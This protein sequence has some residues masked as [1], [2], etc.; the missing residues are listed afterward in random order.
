MVLN[1]LAFFHMDY[2]YRNSCEPCIFLSKRCPIQDKQLWSNFCIINY[3]T[4]LPHT[5]EP[6]WR[7]LVLVISV[8]KGLWSVHTAR[9]W[10]LYS[11]DA[12]YIWVVWSYYIFCKWR[13]WILFFHGHS[14]FI[15]TFL[16]I[17]GIIWIPTSA[18]PVHNNLSWGFLP[19]R[20]VMWWQ[21]AI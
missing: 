21:L 12:L 4:Y 16:N 3:S 17:F 6:Y 2:F 19:S 10:P 8:Q 18:F 9:Y 1:W 14:Y 5:V 13:V 7:T 11:S 15:T 20:D